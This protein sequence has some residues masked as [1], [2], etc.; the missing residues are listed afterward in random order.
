MP[1]SSTKLKM[2]NKNVRY[3]KNGVYQKISIVYGKE[4]IL[5]KRYKCVFLS[6]FG[7][8]FFNQVSI[9]VGTLFTKSNR[10]NVPLRNILR[11]YSWK[12]IY[13]THQD[14]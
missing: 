8:I 7:G 3:E 9:L 12:N 2:L 13:L 4:Y 11:N 10:N 1:L 14:K 5:S 6:S